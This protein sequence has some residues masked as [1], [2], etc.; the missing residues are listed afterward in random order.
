M[1]FDALRRIT[2]NSEN[3]ATE[4]YDS[5]WSNRD[6][7]WTYGVSGSHLGSYTSS[8]VTDSTALSLTAFYRGLLLISGTIAGFPLQIF[9]QEID[10]Q[11]IAGATRK[12]NSDD[13]AYLWSRPNRELV[14]QA[15]WERVIADELRG[16]AF[17]FVVKNSRG[18]VVQEDDV[19][20]GEDW[21]IWNIARG[22]VEVGRL[23]EAAGG[24]PAGTK[25]YQ[26]DGER[27]MFDYSQGG[28]MVHIPNWGSGLVGYDPVQLCAQ[29]FRLGHS[30]GDWAE[31]FFREGGGPDGLITTDQ[32][33]TPAQAKDLVK[34]WAETHGG[35]AKSHGTGFLGN[36]AKYQQISVDAD[37][38]QLSQ[39]R[40]FQIAEIARLLGLPTHLLAA[41][42]TVSTWG[43]GMEEQNRM[44]VALNFKAHINRIEQTVSDD[45]L[46]R[47]KTNRYAKM[48]TAELLRGSTLQLNQSLKLSDYMTNNEKRALME[49]EPIEG[50]D[51]LLAMTN[52]LPLDELGQQAPE[53][54]AVAP[55]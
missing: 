11:G 40:G 29:A 6:W 14:H 49:L 24:L 17:I 42:N 12:I 46:H 41:E 55:A 7:P 51:V 9:Q 31:Q 39:L 20:P 15:F 10:A 47:R 28:E 44:L 43:S 27:L 16:N 23:E 38:A 32:V 5:D 50:G 35:T 2:R 34:T 19:R 3:P 45:L 26:V 37:R 18:D 22:R 48:N 30:A 33:L 52:M 36:G 54:A 21:G 25:V 13:T 53:P 1:I 4:P 8:P